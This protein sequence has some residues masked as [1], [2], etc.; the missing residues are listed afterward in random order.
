MMGLILVMLLLIHKPIFC[1]KRLR[2]FNLLK[3]VASCRDYNII[4]WKKNKD[5]VANVNSVG[6]LRL[7]TLN[8]DIL[9]QSFPVEKKM[10]TLYRPITS[11]EIELEIKN[12]P[13]EKSPGPNGFTSE[14][15]QTF[16]EIMPILYKF[17]QKAEKEGTLPNS[18]YETGTMPIPK[19]DKVQEKKATNQC[20]SN[21][22]RCKIPQQNIR[23]SNPATNKKDYNHN[24]VSLILGTQSWFITPKLIEGRMPTLTTS[25]QH[26]PGG[27]SQGSQAREGNKKHQIGKEEVKHV[28]TQVTWPCGT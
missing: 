21:E 3:K 6:S 8:G 23:T 25:T 27:A 9:F 16:E 19:P 28:C 22:Y 18:F 2:E 20:L 13:T 14:F 10:E 11:R 5:S 4:A 12:L 7:F 1:I 24:Q 15:H 17:F 26:S